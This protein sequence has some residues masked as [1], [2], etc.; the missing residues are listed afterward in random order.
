MPALPARSRRHLSGLT[1][2]TKY[3]AFH[4][5][6]LSKKKFKIFIRVSKKM[7]VSHVSQIEQLLLSFVAM[8]FHPSIVTPYRSLSTGSDD[9]DNCTLAISTSDGSSTSIWLELSPVVPSHDSSYFGKNPNQTSSVMTSTL[10][11][12]IPT[13]D[14]ARIHSAAFY[15]K[16]LLFLGATCQTII[17]IWDYRITTTTPF[18][19]VYVYDDNVSMNIS[20]EYTVY[21]FTD[22][23]YYI[24]FTLGPALYVGNAILDIR[25]SLSSQ[26]GPPHQAIVTKSGWLLAAATLFGVGALCQIYST[27]LD[28]VYEQEDAWCD[29]TYLLQTAEGRQWFTSNYK[30]TTL[31][32]HLY[33]LSGFLHLFALRHTCCRWGY[34]SNTTHTIDETEMSHSSTTQMLAS[35]LVLCGTLLFVVGTLMDCL[36]SWIYDPQTLRGIYSIFPALNYVVL[37][38]VDVT[39]SILWNA[40]AVLYLLAHRME[41][42]RY[43]CSSRVPAGWDLLTETRT[44]TGTIVNSVTTT[45]SSK[46]R[47]EESAPLV[48]ESGTM[49]E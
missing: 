46:L 5:V 23:L 48:D 42:H 7:V 28:D 20:T 25:E 17:S 6:N 15:S 24:L 31:S 2:G 26:V 40:G 44:T 18:Y 13:K 22:R 33:L 11:S 29:D 37:G 1:D 14:A 21:S 30:M 45:T 8:L 41:Y 43:D 38:R 34:N 49:C 36:I 39:S 9:D 32:M 16:L 4:Q 35:Q 12:S 19:Y 47:M 3:F 10:W 27:V